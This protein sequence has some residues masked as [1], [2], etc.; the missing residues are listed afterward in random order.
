MSLGRA[1][2]SLPAEAF[3]EEGDF[4]RKKIPILEGHLQPAIHDALRRIARLGLALR[5]GVTVLDIGESWCRAI[6]SFF[7]GVA[8]LCIAST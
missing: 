6:V 4:R 8:V 5:F 3:F 1:L 7:P 2:K